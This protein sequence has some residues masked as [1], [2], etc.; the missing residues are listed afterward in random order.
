MV[1]EYAGVAFTILLTIVTSL[2]LGRYLFQVF[3]ERTIL[4]R[5]VPV[6]RLALRRG[7]GQEQDW[8]QY[9]RSLLLSNVVLWLAT[10]PIVLLQGVLPLNPDGIG[11]MKPTLSLNT[12]ASFVTNTNLQHYSGETGLSYFSQLFVI[13]FLQFVTAATGMAAAVAVMR[14]LAG[15]RLERLGNFYVDMTRAAVRVLLPL[16]LLVSVFLMGQGRP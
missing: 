4:I 3:A 8:K 7:G 13:T 11:G 15:H 10:F 2:P 9:S 6:E 12:I 5:S 16:S 1:G 14:G